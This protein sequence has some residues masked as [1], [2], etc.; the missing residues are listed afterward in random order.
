MLKFTVRWSERQ[1]DAGHKWSAK[2]IIAVSSGDLKQAR[3]YCKTSSSQVQRC[4][5]YP[6]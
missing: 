1:I 6:I 3:Q 4:K 2:V 5:S